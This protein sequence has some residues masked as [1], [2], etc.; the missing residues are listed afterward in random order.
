MSILQPKTR[1]LPGG[2]IE[3][4]SPGLPG[5]CEVTI[6]IV[7][8]DESPERRISEILADQPGGQLFKTRAEGDQSIK[9][10]RESWD[11]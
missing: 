1:I 5:G 4:H 11:D 6:D 9:E 2:R 3:I 7:L 8:E 10:E